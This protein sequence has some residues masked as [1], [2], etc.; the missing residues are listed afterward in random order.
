[1]ASYAPRRPTYFDLK[2]HLAA[3]DAVILE[4]LV[5]RRDNALDVVSA[6]QAGGRM[7]QSQAF[8][9]VR[10]LLRHSMQCLQP[11]RVVRHYS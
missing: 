10:G 7:S 1:M 3:E 6:L 9:H 2:A 5:E 8:A 11:R 4:R